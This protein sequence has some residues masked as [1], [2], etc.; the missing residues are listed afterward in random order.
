MAYCEPGDLALSVDNLKDIVDSHYK[1][2][3]DQYKENYQ[4]QFK[5]LKELPFGLVAI[6]ALREAFPCKR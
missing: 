1:K 4:K 5:D 6:L 2:N 3:S